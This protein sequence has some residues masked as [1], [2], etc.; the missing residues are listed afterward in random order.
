MTVLI[1]RAVSGAGKTFFANTLKSLYP[2]AV[3][4]SADFYF[5]HNG[6]YEFDASKLGAA[7]KS[8]QEA[9]DR[10]ISDKAELIIV[11]NTNCRL[12]DASYYDHGGKAAGYNVIYLVLENRHG[13]SN[14]HGVP[15]FSIKNQEANLKNSLK[16]S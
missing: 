15:T 6:K 14:T 2:A 16:L 3:I 8:C 11:S 9:F 4:V 13:N 10:A 5:E 12:K 7:H 1:L